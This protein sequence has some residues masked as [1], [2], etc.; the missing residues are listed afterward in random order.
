[1]A[2]FC[3]RSSERPLW[4]DSR[5]WAVFALSLAIRLAWAV[6]IDVVPVADANA[7]D[8]F[9]RNIVTHGVYGWT[10]EEPGGW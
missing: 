10:P 8:T 7:Y 3:P 5:V 4:C 9:A 1:M 6:A 2:S